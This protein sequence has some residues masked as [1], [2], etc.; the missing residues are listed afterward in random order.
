MSTILKLSEDT[1][2][3]YAVQNAIDDLKGSLERESQN[4]KWMLSSVNMPLMEKVWSCIQEISD[5]P[6][7][8]SC[9][10]WFTS[11][12]PLGFDKV[13]SARGIENMVREWCSLDFDPETENTLQIEG[14]NRTKYTVMHVL[15]KY[16]LGKEQYMEMVENGSDPVI[17]IQKLFEDES[18]LERSRSAGGRFPD[19]NKAVSEIAEEYQV[20][21]ISIK[22]NLLNKWLQLNKDSQT[23]DNLEESFSDFKLTLSET[24]KSNDDSSGNSFIRC[25]YIA[26][27]CSQNIL[28]YLLTTGFSEDPSVSTMYK[29]MALKCLVAVAD[30]QMIRQSCSKDLSQ[31]KEHMI[32]MYFMSRLEKLTLSVEF[33][34]ENKFA[35]VESV[36]RSCGHRTDGISLVVDLCLH[37]GIFDSKLWV[38]LLKQ[39][40]RLGMTEELLCS[41]LELNNQPHLWH[42][43]AFVDGW[44]W[45]LLRPFSLASIPINLDQRKDCEKSLNLLRSCPIANDV[46]IKLLWGECRRLGMEDLAEDLG[47]RI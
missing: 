8:L 36:L 24:P 7:A 30:E 3:I 15:H 42:F 26:Q 37:F 34:A 28:D 16:D 18:I 20:S 25:C 5:P 43:P 41:L 44:N 4:V 10:H 35:L 31:V 11:H 39:M 1:I 12:L 21:A 45:L 40:I 38:N 6:K 29:L 46:N 13:L 27:E 2:R 23:N 19:I 22:M 47:T 33:K 32:N 17:I 14:E 9:A